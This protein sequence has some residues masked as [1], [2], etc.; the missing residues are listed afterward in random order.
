MQLINFKNICVRDWYHSRVGVNTGTWLSNTIGILPYKSE[1]RPVGLHHDIGNLYCH[2]ADQLWR[3]LLYNNDLC[4]HC[5]WSLCICLTKL[6]T[7]LGIAWLFMSVNI[8]TTC[9]THCIEWAAHK[10]LYVYY[11]TKT[12]F[13][14]RSYH[15][16]LLLNDR[17]FKW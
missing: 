15:I 2:P 4:I 17:A 16:M 13:F 11:F 7:V 9:S 1:L 14:C 8:F 12:A 3:W 10:T 5:A 6:I